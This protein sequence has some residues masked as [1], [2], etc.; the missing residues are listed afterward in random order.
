[1][2]DLVNAGFE[3]VG[4]FIV[5]LSIYQLHKDKI[6]RG[7]HFAPI[8]FFASWGYW[9]IY[10]Y[11]ELAQNWSAVAAGLMAL[12]NTIYL[13]QILYY[14]HRE[15]KSADSS[16]S[17]DR[18]MNTKSVEPAV[19]SP[20]LKTSNE[21]YDSGCMRKPDSLVKMRGL[22]ESMVDEDRRL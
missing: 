15:R 2:K 18:G 10:Y 3:L 7:V 5:W 6:V 11:P 16:P 1:M 17:D 22:N 20:G 9:N 19:R 8:L 21:N 14:L 4:S 12:T 13:A